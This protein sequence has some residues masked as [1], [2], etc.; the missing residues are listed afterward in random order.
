MNY[1]YDHTFSDEQSDNFLKAFESPD[2]IKAYSFDVEDGFGSVPLKDSLKFFEYWTSDKTG[3]DFEE[4]KDKIAHY[5]IKGKMITIKL[6]GQDLGQ[7]KINSIDDSW[8]AFDILCEHPI[9]LR[10]IMNSAHWYVLGKFKPPLKEET[11]P[12]VAVKKIKK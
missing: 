10:L 4:L 8:D 12:V 5:A 9:A 7:F 11:G 6:D 1:S 3:D 2:K